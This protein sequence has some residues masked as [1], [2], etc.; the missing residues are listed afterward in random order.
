MDPKVEL[1][2]TKKLQEE[3]KVSD[4][5]YAPML[6]KTIVYGFIGLICVAFVAFLT[7]MVWPN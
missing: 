6:V 7:K 1:E 2:V 5:S 4:D 3:R